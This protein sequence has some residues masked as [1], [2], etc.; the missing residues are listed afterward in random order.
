MFLP[1]LVDM[2]QLGH[3]D[4]MVIPEAKSYFFPFCDG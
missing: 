3:K 4:D 2:G 1:I